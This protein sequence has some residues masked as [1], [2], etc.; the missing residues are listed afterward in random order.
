MSR[1]P[2]ELLPQEP[3]STLLPR[4]KPPAVCSHGHDLTRP[5]AV[6][7]SR[8][9]SK[10]ATYR[11]WQCKTCARDRKRAQVARGRALPG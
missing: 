4:Q 6:Y 7:W 1:P 11:R 2:A 8:A 10:G 3:G 9:A 5:G